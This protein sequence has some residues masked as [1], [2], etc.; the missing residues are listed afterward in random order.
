MA[1]FN[2]SPCTTMQEMQN[3]NVNNDVQEAFEINLLVH[4]ALSFFSKKSKTLKHRD[5]ATPWGP[6]SLLRSR[7]RSR[8]PEKTNFRKRGLVLPY[9]KDQKRGV[10]KYDSPLASPCAAWRWSIENAFNRP[11]SKGIPLRRILPAADCH[12]DRNRRPGCCSP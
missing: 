12:R 5:F 6:K 3:A 2:A 7:S 1:E 11:T 4:P 10:R 8:A 9:S